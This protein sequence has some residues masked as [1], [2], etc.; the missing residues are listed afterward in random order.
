MKFAPL[1]AFSRLRMVSLVTRSVPVLGRHSPF[2][3][4]PIFSALRSG[5]RAPIPPAA[6]AVTLQHSGSSVCS[7]RRAGQRRRASSFRRKAAA[8]RARHLN[9]ELLL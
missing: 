8:V 6:S 1:D 7:I 9:V 3:G 5:S 2:F 4:P